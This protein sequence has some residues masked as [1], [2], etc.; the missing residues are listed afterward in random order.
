[1]AEFLCWR[2]Y[3]CSGDLGLDL[4]S[5]SVLVAILLIQLTES[6]GSDACNFNRLS[7]ADR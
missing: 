6:K 3:G 4:H 5:S 1:M 2:F 7:A